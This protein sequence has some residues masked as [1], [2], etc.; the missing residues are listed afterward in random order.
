MLKRLNISERF[1]YL[2]VK[3]TIKTNNKHTWDYVSFHV[4]NTS[5][6]VWQSVTFKQ[7]RIVQNSLCFIFSPIT[8]KWLAL[9]VSMYPNN[10]TLV[11]ITWKDRFFFEP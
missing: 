7:Q 8:H 10:V 1:V 11:N 5:K 9:V 2:V 6:I 3:V 4:N